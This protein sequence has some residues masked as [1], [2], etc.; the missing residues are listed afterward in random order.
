MLYQNI[1]AEDEPFITRISDFAHKFPEHRHA[2]IEMHYCLMGEVDILIDKKLYRLRKGDLV[3]I[4][5]MA[6][7]EVPDQKTDAPRRLLSVIVGISF[8]KEHFNLFSKGRMHSPVFTLDG[9]TKAKRELEALL[10]ETAEYSAND[11]RAR[12]L[13]QGNL[14]KICYYLSECLSATDGGIHDTS[15]RLDSVENIDNALDLIYYDYRKPLTVEDAAE[16]TGYS[17]SNF[18]RI[19]KKITGKTFHAVLNSQRIE[20]A[21][22]LL[23]ESNLSVS[24][25]AELA[26]LGDAKK[27]CRLFKE[28]KGQTPGGYRKRS[29]SQI[30]PA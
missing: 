30:D 25:I 16:I 22:S 7:H 11:R 26:G 20:V 12:L 8:L 17:K 28:I 19:F 14:Y 1:L 23:S 6:S 29:K 5:P 15:K 27:L 24:D 2:D 10:T 4:E 3:F 9:A 21:A 13:I 18:C